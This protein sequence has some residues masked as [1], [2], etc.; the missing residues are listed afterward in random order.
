MSRERTRQEG[1]M[2]A[3]L[4]QGGSRKRELLDVT[5]LRC[6]LPV[7]KIRKCLTAMR[8]GDMLNVVA[9]DPATQIDIPHFCA[10][11]GHELVEQSAG[12]GVFQFSIRH[13]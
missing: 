3:D 10:E 7:L 11:A 4:D 2:S 9:T 5:G 1:D 13:G 6:P 12:D 8:P